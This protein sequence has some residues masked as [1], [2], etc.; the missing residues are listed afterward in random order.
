MM[1]SHDFSQLLKQ[2]QQLLITETQK[3]FLIKVN[4]YIIKNNECFANDDYFCK[5]LNLSSI[6]HFKERIF[7]K[8]KKQNIISVTTNGE[9]RFI[10]INYDVLKNSVV[11]NNT[12]TT[13]TPSSELSDTGDDQHINQTI[14]QPQ[15]QTMNNEE[16][17]KLQNLVFQLS[18]DVESLKTDNARLAKNET[19]LKSEVNNL[20]QQLQSILSD[21]KQAS[22]KVDSTHQ[23]NIL[24]EPTP[25]K[26]ENTAIVSAVPINNNTN[27]NI[28]VNNINPTESEYRSFSTL[29]TLLDNIVRHKLSH[30]DN[31]LKECTTQED[32][33]TKNNYCDNAIKFN[34]ILNNELKNSLH[35]MFKLNEKHK[36]KLL[37]DYINE[38]VGRVR[39]TSNG[40]LDLLKIE[41]FN[42]SL[43]NM[44]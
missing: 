13:P 33:I 36:G 41:F 7:N 35:K 37:S 3:S 6:R 21:S 30:N 18:N 25:V 5:D 27:T 38:K 34:L 26:I 11:V 32:I 12:N 40:V 39:K 20:K 14:N 8:L 42:S 16:F 4:R 24:I 31:F 22:I 17:I 19:I 44:N 28:D 10:T 15:P 2:Q 23:N 9:K 43:V 1:T 29:R